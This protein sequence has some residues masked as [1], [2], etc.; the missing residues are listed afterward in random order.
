MIRITPP[1][2]VTRAELDEGLK[3]L[4]ASFAAFAE[5]TP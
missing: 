3:S 4:D 5:T 1:L 2:N